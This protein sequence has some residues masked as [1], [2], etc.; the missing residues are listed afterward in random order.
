M[1][2]S[3]IKL[4]VKVRSLNSLQQML[5]LGH[6]FELPVNSYRDIQIT[7]DRN[8]LLCCRVPV[9]GGDRAVAVLHLHHRAPQQQRELFELQQ[10]SQYALGQH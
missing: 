6:N 1:H 4:F 5:F 9:D 2:I 7:F 8:E 3:K 10:L